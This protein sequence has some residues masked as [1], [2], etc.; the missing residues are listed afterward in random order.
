MHSLFILKKAKKLVSFRRISV[1]TTVVWQYNQYQMWTRKSMHAVVLQP[2]R[3]TYTFSQ[4]EKHTLNDSFTPWIR[5]QLYCIEC[6]LKEEREKNNRWWR[7]IALKKQH[8]QPVRCNDLSMSLKLQQKNWQPIS[9][10][11][12]GIIRI[13]NWTFNLIFVRCH[14]LQISDFWVTTRTKCPLSCAMNES[15]KMIYS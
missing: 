9:I 10:E 1:F 3:K 7:V 8:Q 12:A 4:K 13:K 2:W 6:I 11:F 5:L 14:S 15:L